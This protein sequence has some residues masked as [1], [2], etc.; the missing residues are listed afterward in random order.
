MACWHLLH[1][2]WQQRGQDRRHSRADGGQ[3]GLQVCERD[4]GE[5]HV[6]DLGGGA[7]LAQQNVAGLEVPAKATQPANYAAASLSPGQ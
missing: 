6:A 2:N 3:A 4:F 1:A 5:A 7:A